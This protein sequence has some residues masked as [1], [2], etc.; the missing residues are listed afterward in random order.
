MSNELEKLIQQAKLNEPTDCSGLT[1]EQWL[2]TFANQVIDECCGVLFDMHERANSSH[3][4][5]GHAVI[6]LKRYFKINSGNRTIL[7]Y[8]GS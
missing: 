7:T 6:E 5:Y 1:K 4:Y 8:F 2:E 3:N